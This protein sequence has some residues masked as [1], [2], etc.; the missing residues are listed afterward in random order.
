MGQRVLAV[1]GKVRHHLAATAVV[2]AQPHLAAARAVAA[3][4]GRVLAARTVPVRTGRSAGSHPCP[5]HAKNC[6]M[7]QRQIIT[8]Q[9]VSNAVT[10]LAGVKLPNAVQP[11]GRRQ[12]WYKLS[13]FHIGWR[14]VAKCNSANR[15]PVYRNLPTSLC[16]P[17][18]GVKFQNAAPSIESQHIR[19]FSCSLT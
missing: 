16:S 8:R 5:R 2:V 7:E 17:L 13:L 14:K 3:Q 6:N 9:L 12:T 19:F 10:L 18:A 15:K 1:H 4:S 11:I